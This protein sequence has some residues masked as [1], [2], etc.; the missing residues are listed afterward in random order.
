MPQ[1]P[2]FTC[3]D[4]PSLLREALAELTQRAAGGLPERT[5][6]PWPPPAGAERAETLFEVVGGTLS[7][8][9]VL[10]AIWILLRMRR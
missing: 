9:I 6:E 2:A 3:A 10:A 8:L 5:E 4:F 1:D 7:L